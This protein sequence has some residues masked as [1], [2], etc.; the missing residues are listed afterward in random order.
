MARDRIGHHPKLTPILAGNDS[1]SALIPV[2]NQ[3]LIRALSDHIF[4]DDNL[5]AVLKGNRCIPG[6][7]RIPACSR[8]A[9]L[10][11]VDRISG[12][13]T[14]IIANIKLNWCADRATVEP[15]RIIANTYRLYNPLFQR[16]FF[17]LPRSE[18]IR[19][20]PK[21]LA[22]YNRLSMPHGVQHHERTK[23][24]T[25]RDPQAN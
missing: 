16:M 3:F 19:K 6:M 11:R 10:R 25:R 18:G 1:A 7:D 24:H 8:E 12:P 17:A 13:L 9:I 4:V 23:Q 21:L 22:S 20:L 2:E 5:A 14:R 15:I